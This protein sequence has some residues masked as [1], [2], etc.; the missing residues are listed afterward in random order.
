MDFT[1]LDGELPSGPHEI[2]LGRHTLAEL[3]L[4]VGDDVE[5]AAGGSGTGRFTVSGV[6]V[7]P[8]ADENEPGRG[9]VLTVDG[10]SGLREDNPSTYLVV[11]FADGIDRA[12]AEARL[13]SEQELAFSDDGPP[14]GALQQLDGMD[15][16]LGAL[17]LFLGVIG[18]LGLLQHLAVSVRQ[19]RVHHAVLRSLGLARAQVRR[20]VVSQAVV[21]AVLGVAVGVPLGVVV[22]RAAWLVAVGDLGIVDTPAT[23]WFALAAV[24]VAVVAGS[25]LLAVGP[26][27]YAARGRPAEALRTE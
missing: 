23:P 22:G 11:T 16:P 2:A 25:A 12:A 24:V 1:L 5:V 15:G 3:G 20:S 17:A 21:L 10:L 9:A 13:A 8:I 26:G 7:M 4:E 27:W 18:V 6:V 14:P 19:R